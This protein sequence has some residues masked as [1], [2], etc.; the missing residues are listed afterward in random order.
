[1]VA[2]LLDFVIVCLTDTVTLVV[3]G[4]QQNSLIGTG[5]INEHHKVYLPERCVDDSVQ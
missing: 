4:C 2:Q 5:I 1:M 3:V